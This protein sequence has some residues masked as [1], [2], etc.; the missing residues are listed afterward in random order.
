MRLR[1]ELLGSLRCRSRLDLWEMK[2]ATATVAFV[3]RLAAGV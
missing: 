1:R 2:K 3:F